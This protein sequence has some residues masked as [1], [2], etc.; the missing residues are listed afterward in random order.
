MVRYITAGWEFSV[1]FGKEKLAKIVDGSRGEFL[2]E[3]LQ[4]LLLSYAIERELTTVLDPQSSGIMECMHLTMVDLLQT[5]EFTAKD[6]WKGT[7]RMEV[8]TF[9][10][11]VA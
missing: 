1:P 2:G 4:E 11:T 7:W 5:I 10:Q 9:L 8:N 3:E 6:D